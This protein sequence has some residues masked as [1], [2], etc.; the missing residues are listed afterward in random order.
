MH[1]KNGQF[2]SLKDGEKT[3]AGNIDSG[4]SIPHPEPTW[5]WTIFLA[6]DSLY[7]QHLCKESVAL[8][9]STL[10]YALCSCILRAL[11]LISSTSDF[12]VRMAVVARNEGFHSEVTKLWHSDLRFCLHIL[13]TCPAVSLCHCWFK[14]LHSYSAHFSCSLIMSLGWDF[15]SSFF[16]LICIYY[17][18]NL[19]TKKMSTLWY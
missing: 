15:A 11:R 9:L 8:F 1:R 10:G 2:A 18:L 12:G 7:Q 16:L 3:Y 4:D 19:Q 14:I 6:S 17:P 13:L 5:V